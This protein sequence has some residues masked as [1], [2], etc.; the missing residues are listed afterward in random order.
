[1][2]IQSGKY[3]GCP[4][5]VETFSP[6]TEK[7][8]ICRDCNRVAT[9]GVACCGSTART[10]CWYYADDDVKVITRS[11]VSL[12]ATG[13]TRA[14]H[15]SYFAFQS[16]LKC[17]G[18]KR[19]GTWTCTVTLNSQAPPSA[20]TQASSTCGKCPKPGDSD[21]Q[22]VAPKIYSNFADL[23]PQ[24]RRL[25]KTLS[26][27]ATN[28]HVFISMPTSIYHG[29]S[30]IVYGTT[31]KKYKIKKDCTGTSR[32]GVAC[33]AASGRSIYGYYSPDNV[34]EK[35]TS[36]YIFGPLNYSF[37][38]L[39]VDRRKR[40]VLR[41]KYEARK[42]CGCF[43]RHGAFSMAPLSSFSDTSKSVDI[44]QYSTRS[45]PKYCVDPT[46]NSK[47]WS[48]EGLS[49]SQIKDQ[50]NEVLAYDRGHLIPANHFDHSKLMIKE[51]NFMINILPQINKMNRGAWLETEMIVECLRDKEALTIYG[52]AVYP[53]QNIDSKLKARDNWFAKYM[54]SRI[55][56]TFGK[57]LLQVATVFIKMIMVLSR[58]GFRTR[59]RPRRN[60]R[61]LMWFL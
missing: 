54:E 52:G 12:D 51:S 22:G 45:Y 37:G 8:K 33:C 20:A 53:T 43:D 46:R 9:N 23:I 40:G 4:G 35:S 44:Q 17:V 1:M 11:K 16:S 6:T 27:F 5:K 59:K 41:F 26:T 30:G 56:I 15:K 2:I 49:A 28:T 47:A 55:H 48:M 38:Q 29:C 50:C 24:R 19:A 13:G 58:F 10:Q 7:A 14:I 21:Y 31:T 60:A 34:E 32:K 36:K 39:W 25:E 42:D 57:L 61:H 3:T 18:S